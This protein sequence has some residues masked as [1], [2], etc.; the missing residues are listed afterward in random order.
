[1]GHSLIIW[2][3]RARMVQD[4]HSCLEASDSLSVSLDIPRFFSQKHL[5][6]EVDLCDRGSPSLDRDASV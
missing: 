2:L 3:D 1:M 4:Q 6:E 5:L